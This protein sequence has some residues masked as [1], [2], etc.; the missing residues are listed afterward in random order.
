VLAR[1]PPTVVMQQCLHVRCGGDAHC[2]F[3]R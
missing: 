2:G 1:L 3:R